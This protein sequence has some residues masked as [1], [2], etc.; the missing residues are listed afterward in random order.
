MG[1][2]KN[3]ERNSDILRV[4][5][6]GSPKLRTAI[7]KN[8]S[9]DCIKTLCEICHNILR[10]NLPLKSTKHLYKHRHVLRRIDGCCIKKKHLSGYS[11]NT[12]KARKIFTQNGGFLAALI[13]LIPFI[14]K[15]ILGG[16]FGAAGSAVAGKVISKITG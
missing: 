4:L 2:Y 13:P 10:G 14:G 8:C 5:A 6:N 3:I 7:V 16:I 11:V 9:D 12:G 15:A 1:R